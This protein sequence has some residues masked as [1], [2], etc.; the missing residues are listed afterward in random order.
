MKTWQADLAIVGAGVIWGLSYIFI[1]WGLDN[2]SPAVFMS[3]RFAVALAAALLLCGRRL[4]GVG[5]RTVRRGLALGLLMGGGYL[6]QTY[7]VNF[8]DVSRAAFII[9][10]I[11]PAIP[12]MAYLL[13]RERPKPH[14]L[15]GMAVA[16][17]GLWLLLDPQF[18]GLNL[19]DA[20]ALLSIPV[21]AL[22]MIYMNVYTEGDPDPDLTPRLMVLQFVGTLPLALAAALIFESGLCLPPLHP[23]LGKPLNPTGFF[24]AGLLF[25]ALLASIGTV[26]IQTA[27]Q[28]YTT[29]VQA[30][31]CFQSEPVTA[32]A[33]AVLLLGEA[34]TWSAGLGAALILAGVLA[35]E[36]G[37]LLAAGRRRP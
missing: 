8:T 12:L 36:L 9:A 35:S 23:D 34:L 2:S 18:T 31:I 14:N 30:M 17:A 7:S 22:Y 4:R 10:L 13:F 37:G 1:R 11:M 3:G 19:G 33:A 32:L 20:L 6:L 26:F 21:W 15:A 29:P 25:C 5:R 16:L 24:W 28:K 27:C